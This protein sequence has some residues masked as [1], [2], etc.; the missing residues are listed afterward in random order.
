[1]LG[2]TFQGADPWNVGWTYLAGIAVLVGSGGIVWNQ[3]VSKV[4]ERRKSRSLTTFNDHLHGIHQS[5]EDLL[6]SR[7]DFH[8]REVFFKAVVRQA[9][10]MFNLD[11]VRVCV[12]ELESADLDDTST[13]DEVSSPVYLRLATSAGRADPPREE[14]RTD[15]DHGNAAVMA[16]QGYTPICVHDVRKST[17]AVDRPAGAAWHSFFMVPLRG[18]GGLSRGMLTVDTRERTKFTVEDTSIAGTIAKLIVLG[19]DEIA[20]S[21]GDTKPEVS[22]VKDKLASLG[23]GPPTK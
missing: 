7:R 16:A 20:T 15:T 9:S 11:G 19:L 23:D 17:Q 2:S 14:F 5:I 12:Y 4:A 18:A 1:M 3:V 8:A 13:V 6:R 10:Q 21:A 22:E